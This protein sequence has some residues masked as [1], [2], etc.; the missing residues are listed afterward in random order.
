VNTVINY[1]VA[2]T[3]ETHS[4]HQS[5]GSGGRDGTTLSHVRDNVFGKFNKRNPL[6]FM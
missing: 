5:D 3:M 2:S 6:T 1:D 4:S